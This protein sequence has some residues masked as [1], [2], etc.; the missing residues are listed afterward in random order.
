MTHLPSSTLLIKNWLFTLSDFISRDKLYT[1]LTYMKVKIY[2][3]LSLLFCS[4]ELSL[5]QTVTVS[6]NVEDEFLGIALDD[7]R[8]SLH[9]SDSTM[10]Q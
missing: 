3:L 5:A 6:G 1:M 10:I 7:V 8:V 4:V 2:F 9:E